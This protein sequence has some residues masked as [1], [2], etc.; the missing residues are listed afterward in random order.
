M[1]KIESRLE[2]FGNNLAKSRTE[3]KVVE[4]RGDEIEKLIQNRVTLTKFEALNKGTQL[5]LVNVQIQ[6]TKSRWVQERLSKLGKGPQ[7]MGSTFR[8]LTHK[9]KKRFSKKKKVF[10]ASEDQNA[11]QDQKQKRVCALFMH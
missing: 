9:G 8:L 11:I 5:V 6:R 3:I 1:E 2:V 10:I 4:N 7:Y